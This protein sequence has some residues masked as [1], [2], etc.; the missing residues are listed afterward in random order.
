MEK[1]PLC[2]TERVAGESLCSNSKCGYEFSNPTEPEQQPEPDWDA[3]KPKSG[4][5]WPESND[6]AVQPDQE[7]LKEHAEPKDTPTQDD[8]AIREEQPEQEKQESSNNVTRYYIEDGVTSVQEKP[9]TNGTKVNGQ[10]ITGQGRKE[11]ENGNSIE[12]SRVAEVTFQIDSDGQGKILLPNNTEILFEGDPK[13]VGR[14]DLAEFLNSVNLDPFEIS[15]VQF[16]ISK[17]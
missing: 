1:C 13:P 2:D 11:L 3:L 17:E 16:T 7:W 5:D 8:T 15:R 10:N 4:A 12:L 9:S 6:S 14:D